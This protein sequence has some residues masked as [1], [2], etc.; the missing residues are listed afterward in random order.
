MASCSPHIIKIGFGFVELE[1]ARE[2]EPV[3]E[4]KKS[5]DCPNSAFLFLLC[6]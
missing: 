2:F 3:D 4:R 1:D 6:N 5:L